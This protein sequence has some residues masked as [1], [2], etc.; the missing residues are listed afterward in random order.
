MKKIIS[1][2]SI[3]GLLITSSGCTDWLDLR[4]ESEIVLDDYWQNESQVTQVLSACYRSVTE[5]DVMSRMLVWGEL[6]SDNV[7]YG[8]GMPSDMSKMLNVDITADNGYCHWGSFYTVINYCNNFLHYAPGVVE[9]DANFT[10]S[11]L[12]SM[13]AEVLTLRALMYFYLVRTFENVPWVN[14]P[15][16]DDAQDYRIPQSPEDEILNYIV[17]DLQT[18]LRYSRDNFETLERTKGRVTTNAIRALLADIYLWQ[19]EYSKCIEMCDQILNDPESDLELEM[20]EDVISKVFYQGNS[21]E[22]IFELQ[23][24]DD[25]M[26]N[27]V[28]YD[29]FGGSGR[30]AGQWSFPAPLVT[31]R[32]SPFNYVVGSGKESSEDLREKDFLRQVIG[33][34]SYYV[35][36]YAGADRREDPTTEAS[37]YFYRNVTANWIVYRLSEIYLMKAE[38]MIQLE[39]NKEQAIELINTI[40]MRSNVEEDELGLIADNYS[41]KLKLD[42]LYMRERQRELMFEGKRWFDLMR[43]ARRV[44]SPAPLLS[45]VTK[46]FTGGSSGEANKMSVM[47][48]LYLPVHTD[49]LKANSALVQNEFYKV[50]AEENK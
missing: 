6:R 42:E 13:E 49:E 22:S 14:E 9:K 31:G 37:T 25:Q 8:S 39:S 20:G 26:F 11:K 3:A 19:E 29:Y 28:V 47:E 30:M 5:R 48:A 43:M 33:G 16:I 44:D 36:K 45:Y 38:A 41:T 2:L 4:P 1:I 17:S 27:S 34:D 15:S 40:Y 23:F 21:K 18:A 32:Y 10:E 35:F 7:W 12:H 50:Q 46:K 24:D